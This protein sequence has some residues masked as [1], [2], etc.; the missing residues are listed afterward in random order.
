MLLWSN[1]VGIQ[2]T[3]PNLRVIRFNKCPKLVSLVT[4]EVKEQPQLDLPA[5]TLR[6]ICISHCNALESLPKYKNTCVEYINIYRD[7]SLQNL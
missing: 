3:F 6:E 1:D 4:E 5:S 7:T 2:Q